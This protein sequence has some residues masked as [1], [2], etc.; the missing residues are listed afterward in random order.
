MLLLHV[1]KDRGPKKEALARLVRA[2]APDLMGTIVTGTH[3]SARHTIDRIGTASHVWENSK[4]RNIM[5]E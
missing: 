5:G 2:R 3:A 1:C 4:K